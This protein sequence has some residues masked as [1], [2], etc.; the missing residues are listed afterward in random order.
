MRRSEKNRWLGLIF[1]SRKVSGILQQ[2]ALV[3][4]L[5]KINSELYA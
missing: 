1:G 3:K 5:S 4:L 2:P